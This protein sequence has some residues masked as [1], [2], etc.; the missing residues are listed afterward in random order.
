MPRTK[1]KPKRASA[2]AKACPHPFGFV[3]DIDE[4]GGPYGRAVSRWCFKCV[5]YVSLGPASEAP[6][7]LVEARAAEL[8]LAPVT[9]LGFVEALGWNARSL[10]G[11]LDDPFTA[12][13]E[14][15]PNCSASWQ[16]GWLAHVI[17]THAEERQGVE[18]ENP[19]GGA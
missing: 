3:R 5:D 14:Q 12:D 7:T 1:T 8:A 19:S 4:S 10:A 9:A 15:Y 16:A 17:G 13:G 2:K 18:V 6:E 11:G